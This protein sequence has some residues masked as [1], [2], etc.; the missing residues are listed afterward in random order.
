MNFRFAHTVLAATVAFAAATAGAQATL[1]LKESF[2]YPSTNTLT[3]NTI[4][5]GTWNLNGANATSSVAVLNYSLSY[6][7]LPASAGGSALMGNGNGFEDAGLD[8]SPST[9]NSVYASFILKVNNP[10]SVANGDYVFHFQSAGGAAG[11]FHTRVFIVPGSVPGTTFR[12]RVQNHNNDPVTSDTVDRPVGTPVF[13]AASYDFVPGVIND[14]SRLWVN[15]A[16]GLG[17][18]P[19][20]TLT[21]VASGTNTD[22]TTLG[23]VSLRQGG[24]STA[25]TLQI[26]E[27]RVGTAWIDVA[28]NNAAVAEW[29]LYN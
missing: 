16:L 7:G 11:D 3:F 14:V 13:V 9:V 22:L 10:G 8:I 23:R 12:L 18:A 2:N 26:D 25:Q 5:G 1:P 4:N 24:A 6:P 28:P 19:A 29:S 27:L 17:A 21:A 20:A 15:P